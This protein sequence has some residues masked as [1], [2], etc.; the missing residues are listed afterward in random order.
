MDGRGPAPAFRLI[1]SEEDTPPDITVPVP[2][3]N[4]SH[5]GAATAASSHVGDGS[6]VTDGEGG[7]RESAGAAS[8][9]WAAFSFGR[10]GESRGGWRAALNQLLRRGNDLEAAAVNHRYTQ[11]ERARL[12]QFQSIDYLA[13]SSRVYR[14]WLAAQPWGRYWDRWLMM[15]LIGVA[16]GLVGYFLHL[17]VHILA[18]IKYHGTRWLLSHTHVIVGWVFNIT[19]S[20]ALVYASTWLVVNIAPEAG[21]A[22]VAEVTAYLNGCFMPK[23]LNIRTFAVKFLSAATAVGSGLPVGPEGP[24]I[25]MGAIVGAGLSQGH[26]TTLGID[27]GLFRRFQNPKDKRDFVTAGAAMGVA[28]AFSAPIGGLLFVLEEIASFWQQSL[29]WQIFFACMM[30]VLTSDTMRSMQA[31]IGEGQ[32]GMFDSV[33]FE[34]KTQL[35]THVL[36]VVPAA[37]IGIICG[38]CA[39][40]F[41]LINLKVARARQEFFKGRPAKWRMAEPCALIVIFVTLGMILPL[42]FPCTPTQCVIIQGETK[43]LCPEGTPQDIKRIVEDSTELY[44]CSRTAHDSEIPPEWDPDGK[45][46]GSGSKNISVPKAYN[47]LATLMSVP[48]EDAIRH[49]FSRGTHR[50]FGYAAIIVMLIFY[51][52]GAAWTAGSAISSGVFVPMLLIG[53]CIGRL[54]GLVVVDIAAAHGAG[55]QGAPPGVFLPPSPWAWIDPGAFA[56]IGA[57]AFMGGVTRMTL[58]LAVI[59]M[60]MS[61]DVR[62]LLPVMVAIMIAKFVADAATHSLYHGLLEVKCVPFL[63]K[64][65]H[66]TISLDLVEVRYV[67]AAPVVTLREQMRLGDVRDVLRKTRHNG[68]PVVRDTPQ[69]GV[70]VGLVVRDHLMKLLVEAVKRGTCQHLEVP[71]SDLNRQFVDASALE[72]EAAQQMAVLE[73]RPLTPAHFPND[74]SLWDEPLDLTPYIN[75]S[76]VRVPESFTLERAYILFSTMGLRHLVV[77]DEHNRVRG[78]VTR[79]DLLGYKLDEAV[80]RSRSGGPLA[81]QATLESPVATPHVPL[82]ADATPDRF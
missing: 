21:G 5:G 44:T 56:L 29:G 20:L 6:E 68:F 37:A 64:D 14:H 50:E 82:A 62:I 78:M 28:V 81:S 9:L 13:P 69:G 70:C 25:H 24:M 45:G 73:G 55:S 77:V 51:F 32:F 7:A 71:F 67:M 47:E 65:P 22:G 33:F 19:F 15:A 38:I 31:A 23:I 17:S 63:P 74:P 10:G 79:K 43:P 76:A 3:V 12:K 49:L 46:G 11:E 41:T 61:N 54:V 4:G 60:E 30:A 48:G 66:S 36:M 2:P 1:S 80:K 72:S 16:V 57:G 42:F 27:S 35:T 18:A 39:I 34:V 59:I 53:A 26:S 40:I 58:A 75:T 52:L 8:D